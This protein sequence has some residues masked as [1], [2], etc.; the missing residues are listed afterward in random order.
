MVASGWMADRWTVR[1][2]PDACMRV[3]LLLAVSWIP[4]GVA[5]LLVPDAVWAAVLYAP[6]AFLAAGVYSV[7]PAALMQVTPARMRGQAGAIY[8]FSI[9]MIGLGLGPTA[10]ALLTDYLFH[11]VNQVGY[12]LLIVTVVAHV[13]AGLLLWSGRSAFIR[14]RASVTALAVGYAT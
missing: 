11:D 3:A 6:S 4:T 9:N 12:S 10:V 13:L 2:H 8:L 7:G 5:M 14:S 1:G